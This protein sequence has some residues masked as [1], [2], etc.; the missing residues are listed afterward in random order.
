MIDSTTPPIRYTL[1]T[2]Q[3]R[4]VQ[5]DRHAVLRLDGGLVSARLPARWLDGAIIEMQASLHG[6][7][8]LEVQA[9]DWLA[10]TAHAPT[11]VWLEPQTGVAERLLDE[12]RRR[13]SQRQAEVG[14]AEVAA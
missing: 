2:G 8:A 4:L 14:R 6:G 11:T 3:T 12:C 1:A 10:L 5:V 7:A 9:G 13:L